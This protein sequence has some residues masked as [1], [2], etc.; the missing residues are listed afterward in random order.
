MRFLHLPDASH[1]MVVEQPARLAEVIG[2]F[3]AAA[4]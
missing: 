1:A 3:L 4:D 2:D